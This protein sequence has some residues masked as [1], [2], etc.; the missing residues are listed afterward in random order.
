[1]P[2]AANPVIQSPRHAEVHDFARSGA[3]DTQGSMNLE[4][5]NCAKI[6][7]SRRHADVHDFARSGAKAIQGSMNLSC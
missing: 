2:H 6:I 5:Q 4:V 3:K 7:Q 1:M